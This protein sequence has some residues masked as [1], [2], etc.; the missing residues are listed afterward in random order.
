MTLRPYFTDY[1]AITLGVA[2]SLSATLVLLCSHIL[3]RR[4]TILEAGAIGIAL[5]SGVSE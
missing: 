1:D 2:T 3:L 5:L 4:L